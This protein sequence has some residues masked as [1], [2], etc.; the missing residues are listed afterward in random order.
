MKK[1]FDVLIAGGGPA[2]LLAAKTAMELGLKVCLFDLHKNY[3]Q[4]LRACSAQFIMDDGYEGEFLQV[5]DGKIIFS[6]NGF[7]VNYTGKL[8]EVKNKYYFSPQGHRIHFAHDDQSPF[9]LK[10]DKQKLLSDLAKECVDLGVT[11]CMNTK[12]LRGT[13]KGEE[14]EIL[15]SK[16]GET[17]TYIGKKLIIAEGVN[18]RLTKQFGIVKD[19]KTFAKAASV[20]YYVENIK[21]IEDNSWNLFY[22]LA[23]HCYSPI[24]IGPSVHDKNRYEITISCNPQN[25]LNDE[26]YKLFITDSPMADKLKEA[27]LVGKL[28]CTVLASE[29][30][31]EPYKGNVISIGDSAAFVEVEVQ[32]AFMCGFHAANAVKEEIEGN[33]GFQK[34]TEWWKKSFEFNSDEYLLVSQGY[35]LVPT[36]TDEEL[37]YLFGLLEKDLLEGTYSQYKTPKLIWKGIY[38]HIDQVKKDRPAIYEKMQRNHQMTLT[39]TFGKNDGH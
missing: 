3:D 24:I 39:A 36:Y 6:R 8:V 28:G 27:K 4:V 17:E 32:G 7:E 10:F 23:Y 2:G 25:N 20:K 26:I 16:N 15:V 29:A 11:M 22:G 9:A 34:Y 35:A 14:V 19:R 37:D 21:G 30:I 18:A 13:D 33:S 5:R 38:A 12:V 31:K 1:K